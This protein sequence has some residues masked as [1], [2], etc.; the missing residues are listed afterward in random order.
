MNYVVLILW[1]FEY[2][3]VYFITDS[4]IIYI[5][6]PVLVY[7]YFSLINYNLRYIIELVSIIVLVL[8]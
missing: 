1:I 5:L 8:I 6:Q 7:I 3:C 4:Y 2:I